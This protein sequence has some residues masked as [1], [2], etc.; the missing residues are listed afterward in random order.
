MKEQIDTLLLHVKYF[1]LSMIVILIN[2][3]VAKNN[4]MAS[5]SFPFKEAKQEHVSIN[6]GSI[7]LAGE[8]VLPDGKGP[9]PA[10]VQVGGAP[11][12][13]KEHVAA[14]AHAFSLAAQGIATLTYDPRGTGGSDGVY[15][16]GDYRMFV[17]DIHA[18]IDYL[19]NRTDIR[20]DQLCYIGHSEGGFL[21]PEVLS[22][23]EDIKC[24]Y[25]RVAPVRD[26]KSLRT[27]QISTRLRKRK[28]SDS[29]IIEAVSLLDD[30]QEFFEQSLD[31]PKF[32]TSEARSRLNARSAYLVGKYRQKLVDV[33]ANPI[34]P[35]VYNR[36]FLE[37]QVYQNNYSAGKY[38]ERNP[39]APML[40]VFG[41][42]DENL[43]TTA[44][45]AYLDDLAQR[46]GQ[47]I[48]THV[49]P[50]EDHSLFRKEYLPIGGY[51]AGYYD[52]L[53]KWVKNYI[54]LNE[55]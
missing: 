15:F 53:T 37:R 36:A 12:V 22:T 38:L 35:S 26:Y 44:S 24:A 33:M 7:S 21:M 45:V 50:N 31:D 40:Y 34:V 27:Y 8:L 39:G 55:Q 43:D 1:H 49:Y 51:P 13:P 48:K 6:S 54:Q 32:Y 46:T 20:S 17:K 41:S 11:P 23:R 4:A 29:D 25:L 28:V 19:K 30:L 16:S 47:N 18:A 14:R 42:L 9:F 2:F 3:I 52:R 5:D 10:V